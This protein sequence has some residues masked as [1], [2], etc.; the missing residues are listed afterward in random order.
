M[1][2]FTQSLLSVLGAAA[3]FLARRFM[4]NMSES[5]SHKFAAKSLPNLEFVNKIMPD[6]SRLRVNFSSWAVAASLNP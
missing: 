2:S 1:G 6:F 3:S 4:L 5:D